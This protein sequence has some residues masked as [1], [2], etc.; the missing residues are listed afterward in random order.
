[1]ATVAAQPTPLKRNHALL[2]VIGAP[3]V[4]ALAYFVLDALGAMPETIS[5]NGMVQP[6]SVVPVIVVTLMGAIAGVIGL[7]VLSRFTKQP[8]RIFVILGV[9]VVIAMTFPTLTLGASTA[10]IIGLNVLHVVAGGVILWALT[11]A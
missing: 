3:I 10:V 5:V 2:A 1:M 4:T 9:L 8:K 6:F 7:A 11:R